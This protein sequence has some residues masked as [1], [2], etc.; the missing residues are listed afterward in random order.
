MMDLD[1]LQMGFPA[2]TAVG[3]SKPLDRGQTI[4]VMILTIQNP[5][6]QPSDLDQQLR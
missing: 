4:H 1:S 6:S 3:A 2:V 5:E